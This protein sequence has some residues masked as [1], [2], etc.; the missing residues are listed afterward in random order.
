[1]IAIIGKTCV[2]KTFLLNKA[3]ELGYS[4][5]NCDLFFTEQYKYG[6]KCYE[7]IKMNLGSKYV[8]NEEVDK[9]MIKQLI[10]NKN[11]LNLLE[12]LIFPILFEHLKKNDYDF[13][14]IPILY[15]KMVDFESLF[16]KTLNITAS[17]ET[18][19]KILKFKNVDN[20]DFEFYDSI[21][22]GFSKK[23]NVDI[24]MDNISNNIDWKLFFQRYYIKII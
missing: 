22:T 2:G 5:L 6:N 15:S 11:G 3:H 4:T 20:Y 7:L 10:S 8:N 23:E 24:D 13:V 16:Q 12:N 17:M 1:M 9:K 14:E 19:R 18:R 21:N